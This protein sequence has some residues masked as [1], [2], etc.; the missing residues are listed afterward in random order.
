MKID[1]SKLKDATNE[2]Y[3]PLYTNTNRYLILYGGAGSGKS[4]FIGQKILHRL[5]TQTGHR[6]LVIRKVARTLR[7]SVFQLFCDYI[8]SWNLSSLFVINKSDMKISYKMGG[9]ILFMGMDDPEKVKSIERITGI[10]IEEAS[11]LKYQDF[12]Q[13]DLRLRGNTDSY[14]QIILSFNPTSAQSWLK[15]HFFDSYVISSYALKTTYKD[16]K[17]I[18]KQYKDVFE[19]M[20]QQNYE[21]YRVYALGDWGELKGLIL[22]NW[23]IV[24][25]IPNDDGKESYGID[26][27]YNNPSSCVYIKEINNELWVD[28]VLY[29]SNLTNSDLI[30]TLKSNSSH[31]VNIQGYGD[32]AEPQ[33]IEEF[34]RA[35]F[36]VTQAN[37]SVKDSL[38]YLMSKKIHVTRRSSNLINELE[39]YK[40]KEDREGNSLDE[41]IKAN[42]HAID[43][44][45]YGAYSVKKGI[46]RLPI[47]SKN[48]YM[49]KWSSF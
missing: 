23:N 7:N 37:K 17:F 26:F 48:N 28:E 34:K 3:V 4:R 1:L 27:G 31:L 24:D 19:N 39:N 41:P 21:M 15:K 13:L 46:S 49:D 35:G 8:S 30:Q 18:D 43:A 14:K 12:L 40:W 20:R 45:R 16:N 25:C 38:D 32:S 29:E 2:C 42:D 33:R 6:F 5:L 44:F 36:K 11:E 9:E 47:T 10:W 22:T